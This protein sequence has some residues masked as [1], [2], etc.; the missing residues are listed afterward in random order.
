M[1]PRMSFYLHRLNTVDTDLCLRFNRSS[2]RAWVRC[3]FSFISRMGDGLFWY[4]IMLGILLVKGAEGAIPCI[5]ML[6]AGGVGTL[7]YKLIK[8]HTLR[9]RPYQVIQAISLGATPLDKFSFP[10]GHT[11]HAVV[12]ALVAVS[13]Y[14]ALA[15][16]AAPFTLL[17]ATS[18]VVLG[19]HY[20]SDVLAGALI[21]LLIA[22]GS[23]IL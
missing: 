18:R 17:I 15:W 12:F 16:I 2:Q 13:Y 9:A 22:E 1:H 10:S 8:G 20:P 14:P 7:I 3:A 5:H 19:L 6:V 23:M 4:L 11:L 21:G